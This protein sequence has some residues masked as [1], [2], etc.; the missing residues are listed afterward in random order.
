MSHDGTA[1]SETTSSTEPSAR[2]VVDLYARNVSSTATTKDL[3]RVGDA[4]LGS[5]DELDARVDSADES[6]AEI[7]TEIEPIPLLQ[8]QMAE[9]QTVVAQMIFDLNE[10]GIDFSFKEIYDFRKKYL[11]K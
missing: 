8:K 4:L 10:I 2:Y 7:E 5:I 11:K 1:H 9:V 6:I 3:F